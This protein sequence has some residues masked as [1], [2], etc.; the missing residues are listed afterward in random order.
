MK[1]TLEIVKE[2]HQTFNHPIRDKPYLDDYDTNVLRL[3]LLEEE[4][5]EL[6]E[7]LSAHTKESSI[8]NKVLVLD[9]LCDL[10]VV[11]DGTFLSLGF[12]KVKDEAFAEVHKSNMSKLGVDG[13]PILRKDGKFLKGPNYTS[14]NLY[15]IVKRLLE[16]S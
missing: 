5:R 4:W 9:A 3:T 14:P 1:T 2:L 10:Q 15:P 8:Q 13:K 16:E 7:A 12:F 11:L 6:G